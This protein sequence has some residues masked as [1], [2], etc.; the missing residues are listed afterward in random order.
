MS[1]LIK[2]NNI[3][4]RNGDIKA[5]NLSTNM[6]SANTHKGYWGKIEIAIDTESLYRLMNDDAIGVLYI[7]TKDEWNLTKECKKEICPNGEC[8]GE[9]CMDCHTKNI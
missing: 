3:V 1:D 2:L 7:T 4:Q 5:F 8:D 6:I 9:N